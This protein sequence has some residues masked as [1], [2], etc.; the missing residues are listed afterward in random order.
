MTGLTVLAGVGIGIAALAV[1]VVALAVL[2]RAVAALLPPAG[3]F[4]GDVQGL[5]EW[6]A[7]RAESERPRP[8]P[9]AAVAVES[10]EFYVAPDGRVHRRLAKTPEG[11]APAPVFEPEAPRLTARRA[12][13]PEGPTSADLPP[14]VVG[15][16]DRFDAAAAEEFVARPVAPA[17]R[18]AAKPPGPPIQ[19]EEGF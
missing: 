19:G 18:Q 10:E 2:V 1:L 8:E 6:S 14:V 15:D 9:H 13:V 12:T 17:S 4:L 5:R 7:R 16:L 3:Q 11:V